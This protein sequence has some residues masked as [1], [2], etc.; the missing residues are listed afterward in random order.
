MGDPDN[1][2]PTET[3]V[4]APGT[5][6][7]QPISR[8]SPVHGRHVALRA[9]LADFGGWQMPIEY[10]GGGVL[11][12]HAVVREAVGLFDVSHLGKVSVRGSGAAAFI[13][14]TLTNDLGRITAG[15]AQYTLC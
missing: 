3:P 5:G 15:Q 9:K 2:T 7:A 6:L 1:T 8:R 4:V 10:P 11:Q 14:A 13:D 12:E